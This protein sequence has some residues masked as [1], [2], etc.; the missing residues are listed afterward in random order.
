VNGAA[1]LLDDAAALVAQTG[2]ASDALWSA[3]QALVD[4][5]AQP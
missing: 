2:R 4:E 3:Y 1:A 5:E